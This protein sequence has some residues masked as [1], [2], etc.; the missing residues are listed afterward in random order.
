M[1]ESKGV[2]DESLVVP[3]ALGTVQVKEDYEFEE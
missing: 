2:N 1:G 3:Q